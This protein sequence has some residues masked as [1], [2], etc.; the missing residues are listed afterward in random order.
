MMRNFGCSGVW[1]HV[2]ADPAHPQYGLAQLLRR[3]EVLRADVGIWPGTSQSPRA[4]LVATALLPAPSTGLWRA[5]P[6]FDDAAF[7]GLTRI[8]APDGESEAG[9]VA[10]LMRETLET[11]GRTAALVTA[12]RDLARR[13]AAKLGRWGIEIDDTVS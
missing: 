1:D 10:L 12:D 4:A 7:A 5:T 9:A 2:A 6:R 8:E 11:P 13:V 3:M